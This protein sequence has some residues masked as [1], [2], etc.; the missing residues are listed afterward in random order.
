MP[1]LMP[2]AT[3]VWLIDNSSLTFSQ[4]ADFTGL[5][6]VEVKGVADG[7][8]A[9]GLQGGDPYI[10]FVYIMCILSRTIL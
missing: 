10:F 9:V 6:P 3:A 8:V 2:K 5:H 7:E 1:P 4:I